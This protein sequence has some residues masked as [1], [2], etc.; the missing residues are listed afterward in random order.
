MSYI[1]SIRQKI[2][3]KKEYQAIRDSLTPKEI[4]GAIAIY[5]LFRNKVS[6]LLF[7]R[8]IEGAALVSKLLIYS[9]EHYTCI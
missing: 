4:A 6:T 7:I 8:V 3:Q 1:C 2:G 9:N 5:R